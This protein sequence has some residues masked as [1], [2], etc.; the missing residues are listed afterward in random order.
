MPKDF[1]ATAQIQTRF[2]WVSK[3]IIEYLGTTKDMRPAIAASHCVVL[4]SYPESAPRTLIEATSIARP[5]IASD[6]PGF[7]EVLDNGAEGFVCEAKNA[8]SIANAMQAFLRLSPEEQSAMGR[9]GRLK[10]QRKCA[11]QS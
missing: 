10:M 7:T 9:G 4:P 6:V 1:N 8:D 2:P 3:G 5:L 11:K